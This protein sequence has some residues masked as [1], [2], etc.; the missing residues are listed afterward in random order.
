MTYKIFQFYI[1]NKMFKVLGIFQAQAHYVAI[2]NQRLHVAL[3]EYQCA[4]NTKIRNQLL[5]SSCVDLETSF[6]HS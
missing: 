2:L 1:N 5:G 3:L 6:Q 4:V